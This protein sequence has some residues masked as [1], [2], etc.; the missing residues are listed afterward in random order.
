MSVRSPQA[1]PP[2][3]A[4]PCLEQTSRAEGGEVQRGRKGGLVVPASS[5]VALWALP[6]S[7]FTAN[8]LFPW[9]T[10][11]AESAEKPTFLMHPL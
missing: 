1:E 7:A 6:I 5:P 11:H 2:P 4:P 9:K 10:G 8:P 3:R